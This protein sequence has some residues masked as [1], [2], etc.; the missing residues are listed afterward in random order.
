MKPLKFI[1][2]KTAAVSVRTAADLKESVLMKLFWIPSVSS[3][4][5]INVILMKIN[6]LLRVASHTRINLFAV[7]EE[8]VFVGNVCVTE[9]SLGKYMENTVKRMTFLVRIITEI[10]VLGMESVKRADAGASVAG[11]GIGASARPHPP[12]TVSTPRAKCA[13]A[14]A[15]VSAAGVSA[16]IPGA[17]AASVNT[18]PRV[19]QPATKTGIVCN[20][21]TLTICLKLYLIDVKPHVL[22]WN[23]IMWT[24]RQNVSLAQAT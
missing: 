4:M 16:P 2:T 23:S 3:V 6:F 15:R 7:V 11:K 24:R 5:S 13:V 14:E 10:C 9:L 12:S 20:V 8:F 17:S 18:A 19:T 22:S 21:F 1:Y